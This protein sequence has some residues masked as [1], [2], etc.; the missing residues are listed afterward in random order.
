MTTLGPMMEVIL[1]AQ[2]MAAQ[3]AFWRDVMGLRVKYPADSANYSQEFWVELES[4][5][6]TLV[7][8]G[9]GKREIGGDAPKVVFSVAD[10]DAA[11]Q[12][13]LD[14]GVRVGEVR[15]PAPGVIVADG[16]DPEGNKF[17]IETKEAWKAKG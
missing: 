5:P 15:S 4:G 8:H 11:R 3:V 16:V 7:L 17:S 10:M 13:L 6:C 9:G 2:D 12:M 1:Y 14:R